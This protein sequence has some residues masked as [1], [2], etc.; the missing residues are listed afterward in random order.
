M[1]TSSMTDANPSVSATE[2]V[3]KRPVTVSP[4]D[5]ILQVS[6]VP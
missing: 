3:A 1:V 5:N 6:Q 4:I 2:L